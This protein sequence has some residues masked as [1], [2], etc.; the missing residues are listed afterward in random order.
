[1]RV[2]MFGDVVARPGRVAVL[3]RVRDVREQLGADLVVMNAENV[4]GGFSISP[5]HAEELFRAGVDVMTSG[6]HIFDKRE[7]ADYIERQPRLL[8]PANYPRKTPGRG[9]WVGEAG[10]VAV[11][12]VNL[13]GR[14]FMPPSGDDPFAAADELLAG[15]DARVRVRLVDFHAEATSEKIALAR[16]L[17]GRV[18]AVVGTHTH[19][20]TADERILPGGTA[21]ISDIGMTGSQSGCIGMETEDVIARFTTALPRRAGHSNGEVYL[22]AVSIDV[23]PATGRAR[24]ITRLSLPHES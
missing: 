12:V 7:A 2:V 18:S 21:F 6:N 10:G 1:M 17:D 14:V 5:A 20:Q 4:T 9:L 22:R 16:Y 15:L 11:A 3:E 19:V 24:E 13:I 8:R 23:D